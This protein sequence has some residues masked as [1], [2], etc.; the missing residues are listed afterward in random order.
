M[1]NAVLLRKKETFKK[2]F[3]STARV[4]TAIKIKL[5]LPLIYKRKMLEIYIY[6]L[7]AETV[8]LNVQG[9]LSYFLI[10]YF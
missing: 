9:E 6:F 10:Q 3:F 8:K 4:P 7:G 2:L 5:R 1:V